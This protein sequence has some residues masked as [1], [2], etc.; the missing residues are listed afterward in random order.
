MIPTHRLPTH[1]GEMLLKEFLEP[2]GITQVEFAKR[3]GISLQR[4]NEIINEKR[5]VTPET[6][7][8]L[9][10]ALGTSPEAWLSLQSNYDLAVQMRKMGIRPTR[11]G[12]L[13]A[14]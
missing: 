14:V 11:S 13:A 4:L 5:G 6:A 9:A 3:M 2:S 8:L 12:R 1:P 10:A 7:L